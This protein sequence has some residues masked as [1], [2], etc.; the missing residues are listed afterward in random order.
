EMSVYVNQDYAQ[1]T[2][3]LRRYS[4]RLDGFSS[5]RCGYAGGHMVTKPLVFSGRELSLNFSTSAAGGIK[6]G[7][8]DSD[9]NPISGFSL[10]DCQMQIGNEIDRKVSWKSGTDISAVAGKTLRLRF[11]MQDADLYSFQCTP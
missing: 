11:S 10:D 5:L 7:F 9:G 4:L 3:H 6:V 8:E 2:A 1:P